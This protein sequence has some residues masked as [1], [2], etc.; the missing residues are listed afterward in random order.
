MFSS[1]PDLGSF[2]IL[3]FVLYI[4][5]TIVLFLIGLWIAYAVIWRAVRR[6]LREFHKDNPTAPTP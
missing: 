1:S 5:I 3:A 4:V 2:G 6:G